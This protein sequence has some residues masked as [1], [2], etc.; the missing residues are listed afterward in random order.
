MK[1]RKGTSELSAATTTGSEIFRSVKSD[2]SDM[3]S[4]Q[5]VVSM[6]RSPAIVV[7]SPTRRRPLEVVSL[8]Y[9]MHQVL[10]HLLFDGIVDFIYFCITLSN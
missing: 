5:Y 8:S 9:S 3:R 4:C 1:P 7:P 10:N 2:F 6:N